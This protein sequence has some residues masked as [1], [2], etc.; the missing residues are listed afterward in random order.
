MKKLRF[1]IETLREHAKTLKVLYVE[2]HAG[3]RLRF[4]RFLKRYFQKVFVTT[5][6]D[7]AIKIFESGHFDLIITSANLPDMKT[8]LIC[9]KIKNIASKK[10]III[11]S[12]NQ[13]SDEIIELINIGISGY[14]LTPLDERKIIPILSRVVREISDLEMIY[15][16]GDTMIKERGEEPIEFLEVLQ[17]EVENS[18]VEHSEIDNLLSENNIELLVTKY[19]NISAKTFIDSNPVGLNLIVDSLFSVNEDI[20]MHI[21][22]FMNNPTQKNAAILANEFKKYADILEDIPVLSN[23][24]F[25]VKKLSM[26]FETIDYTKDYKEYYDIILAISD[27]LMHWC[28]TIFINQTADNIHYLDKS[29]LADALMLESLLRRDE[30]NLL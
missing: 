11:I 9:K 7:N 1:D 26:T 12:K 5:Y 23:I 10:P 17:N 18:E 15:C 29:F 8:S 6:A 2:N 25:S 22:K 19:E 13:N 20:D 27:D 16:F 14:I 21:N 24:T 4:G 3:T 30:I 28:N